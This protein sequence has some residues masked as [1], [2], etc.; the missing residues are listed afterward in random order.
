MAGLIHTDKAITEFQPA[1]AGGSS[2]ATG[3]SR[4]WA[5]FI[6]FRQPA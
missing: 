4:W 3:F 2:D 1:S 6:F 5:L